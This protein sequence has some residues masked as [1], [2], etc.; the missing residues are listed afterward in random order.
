MYKKKEESEKNVS[1]YFPRNTKKRV[2]NVEWIQ[3]TN[4]T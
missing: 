1:T 3:H 2:T 4:N